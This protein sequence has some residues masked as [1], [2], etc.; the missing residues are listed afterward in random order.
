MDSSW[1][2]NNVYKV[3][4][5][6]VEEYTAFMASIAYDYQSLAKMFSDIPHYL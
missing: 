6:W 1:K 2:S 5:N 3:D 4:I